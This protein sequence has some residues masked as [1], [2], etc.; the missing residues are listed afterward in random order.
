MCHA[1]KFGEWRKT[2][3]RQVTPVFFHLGQ[4]SRGNLYSGSTM[5]AA[6]T[7]G[8]G[9]RDFS[10]N[11]ARVANY[12]NI[13]TITCS[14]SIHLYHTYWAVKQNMQVMPNKS[15]FQKAQISCIWGS[16]FSA[17]EMTAGTLV[18]AAA[19]DVCSAH[20]PCW[21]GKYTALSHSTRVH[22]SS[23]VILKHKFQYGEFNNLCGG[24][25]D[26]IQI[27]LLMLRHW[28][29]GLAQYPQAIIK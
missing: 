25:Y 9:F 16:K 12:H 7:F 24:I 22:R 11:T 15:S 10:S 14:I 20:I 3:V 26:S 13:C 28:K 29:F 2:M 19:K 8:F 21:D 4:L 5:L 27:L 17:V 18:L 23:A 6:A 1:H